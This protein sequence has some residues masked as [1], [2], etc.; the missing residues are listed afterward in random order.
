MGLPYS[1]QIS[2]GDVAIATGTTFSNASL[3]NMSV[4]VGFTPQHGLLE[5]YGYSQPPARSVVFSNLYS[6]GYTG[7]VSGTVTITG[8]SVNFGAAVTMYASGTGSTTVTISG[9]SVSHLRKVLGNGYS[10][11]TFQKAPGQHAYTL[12]FSLSGSGSG[13]ISGT[14]AD[15]G[16][17]IY[18]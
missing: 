1:G 12:N 8:G 3:T 15:T 17:D 4:G 7:S 6:I 5:F 18:V 10:S 16:I 2:M 13:W 9:S 14:W 11:T